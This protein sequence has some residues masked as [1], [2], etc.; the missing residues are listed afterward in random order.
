MALSNYEKQKRWRE[1]HRALYNLQQRNRRKK[2]GDAECKSQTDLEDT[3]SSQRICS[4]AAPEVR[5]LGAAG[6]ETKKV[7][8]FRMIVLPEEKPAT[9]AP[10]VDD[11]RSA[12]DVARGIYRNDNGGVI[13]KFAWEKLKK[14]KEHAKENNFEI[15]DYSQ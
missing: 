9:E 2:G 1:K 13:S 5:S 7:G 8:E 4:E 14:M 15:D 3:N 12:A 10:V 11:G 6:F